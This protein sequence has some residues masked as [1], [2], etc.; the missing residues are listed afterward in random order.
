[1]SYLSLADAKS[2]LGIANADTSEDTLITALIAAA[3][4]A[5]E[6]YCGR[7]FEAVTAMR[8]YGVSSMKVSDGRTYLRLDADL[9]SVT[10]LTNGDGS[11]I[12]PSH[13]LLLHPNMPPYWGIQLKSG[14]SWTLPSLDAEVSVAGS[15]GYSVTP[16]GMIVQ[17]T[18]EYVHFLYHSPDQR[19]NVKAGAQR[20]DVAPDHIRRL[21]TPFVR[22]F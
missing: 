13:Y 5:I 15:W 12:N 11:A 2:Y 6:A 18:R 16:P 8:R 1:M 17:A 7:S 21:L 19:R 22:R 14:V 3:Q 4:S 10:A 9:L 20:A